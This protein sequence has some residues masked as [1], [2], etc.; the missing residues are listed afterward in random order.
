MRIQNSVI[1]TYGSPIS[2]RLDELA[3]FTGNVVFSAMEI[4][5]KMLVA[6]QKEIGHLPKDNTVAAYSGR[7]PVDL[8]LV[9]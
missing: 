8:E 1:V 7:R 6:L 3:D 2:M 5:P 9:R 4:D